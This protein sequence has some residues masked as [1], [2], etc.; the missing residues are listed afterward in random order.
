MLAEPAGLT[1]SQLSARGQST[2]SIAVT[3]RLA[4]AL[5]GDAGRLFA[6]SP[7]GSARPGTAVSPFVVRPPE[8]AA[9]VRHSTRTGRRV[10]VPYCARTSTLGRGDNAY[11]DASVSRTLRAVGARRAEVVV[12]AH[13][14]AARA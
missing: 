1:K 7:L 10:E 4:T 11:F 3:L 2:P 12:A 6:C 14:E 8:R 13:D 9:D 5:G